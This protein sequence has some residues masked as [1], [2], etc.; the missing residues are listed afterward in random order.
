MSSGAAM[1][2]CTDGVTA[3]HQAISVDTTTK[4]NAAVTHHRRDRYTAAGNCS[5]T[6]RRTPLQRGSGD[7]ATAVRARPTSPESRARTAASGAAER[8]TDRWV[9][10]RR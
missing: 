1:R 10:T 2:A 5:V 4:A 9:E 8:T 3:T 6:K 7:P